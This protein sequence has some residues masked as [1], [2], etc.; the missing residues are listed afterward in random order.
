MTDTYYLH[1]QINDLGGSVFY[2][3]VA[4]VWNGISMACLDLAKKYVTRK[5][6]GDVGMR[7]CDYPTIQVLRRIYNAFAKTFTYCVSNT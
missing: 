2:L 1:R 3:G 5:S 4:A 7:I 6:H